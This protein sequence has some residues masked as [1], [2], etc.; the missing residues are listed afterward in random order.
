M[1]KNSCLLALLSSALPFQANAITWTGTA[2]DSQWTTSSNWNTNALP[3]T[4][5]TVTINN[6]DTVVFP[7]NDW[8]LPAGVTVN[9][10][11]NSQISNTVAAARLYGGMTF[12][13]SSGSGMSGAYIDLQ[14]G[15]LN[16]TNGSTFTPNNIQH[17]GTTTYG[18]TLAN[19]GFTTLTPGVL[20]Q[21]VTEDWSD[22]TFNIDVSAYDT[23][24]G[25]VLD[26]IDYNGHAAAYS[27]AF[28]PT[29]NIIDG[30]TGLSGV[31][32]FDT[33][34][35][36][37]TL[38]VDPPGND[39]PIADDQ[40]L[41]VNGSSALPITLT[42]SDI[43]SDPLTYTIV[44]GPTQGTLSGTPPNLTYTY[45]GSDFTA[46]S[47]TFKAND[48]TVDS[49]IATVSLIPVPQTQE[50]F[51]TSMHNK[52][53]TDPLNAAT[54]TTWTEPHS[55]GSGNTITISR[56]TYEL[57]PLTGT[58]HTANP[59]IAA[60]YAKPTTGT[61][62]P[63]IV[64]NHGGGQ[65]ALS[66]Y[67]KYWAEQGYA[68]TCINWGGLHLENRNPNEPSSSGTL[69]PNTNWDG[70]A[71]G[72]SRPSTATYPQDNP[73]TDAIFWAS[74]DPA[75]FS[76]GQTLYDIPHP[77]NSS[78]ILNGYAVRRA[79]T[80]L[81]SLPEVD[82]SRIGVLGWSMG[83][84]TT[85]MSST[86]PRID[87]LAPAVGGTGF[88]FEDFW[89]VPGSARNSSGWQ[90]IPLFKA[91]VAD[92]AYWPHVSVPVMFLNGSK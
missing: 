79:I 73:I 85:M 11:G 61:N 89:G 78:W 69:H 63:G 8:T 23:A 52:I 13:F 70:L 64:Q 22:V 77:I 14:N 48:G 60:Y 35:S 86:D 6:G 1:L 72:F 92:Q 55:D 10:S 44:S 82:G 38:T 33:F 50:D 45:T 21:G 68:A 88:L 58:Q 46:D 30:G 4:N 20:Y 24:N 9:V 83:G 40:S 66:S 76:D 5:D 25:I 36:T 18:I 59:V 80:Y 49:N 15:T 74:I 54:H 87:V 57:G 67:A 42:A 31:L 37:V 75:T 71:A 28:T 39:A 47:L 17:R 19:T 34:S 91:T 12:N 81:Q 3:V 53:L 51:W 16:F 41:T 32:T 62:L 7:G 26:L 43:E 84:R 29:V 27:G 2:G 65:F 90:D 56:I